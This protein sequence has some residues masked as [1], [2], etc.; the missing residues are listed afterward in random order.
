VNGFVGVAVGRDII[1][2]LVG[3]GEIMLD[4]VSLME[5]ELTDGSEDGK[6]HCFRVGE[7]GSNY[8]LDSRLLCGRDW[9]REGGGG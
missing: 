8:L 9:G 5:G 6:V 4:G 7:Q 1:E 2:K 3:R